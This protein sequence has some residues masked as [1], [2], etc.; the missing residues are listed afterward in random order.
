MLS[1]SGDKIETG[2][3]LMRRDEDSKRPFLTM[4]VFHFIFVICVT[5]SAFLF[6][7]KY[8]L[9]GAYRIVLGLN[10]SYEY[11]GVWFLILRRFGMIIIVILY[12]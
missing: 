5:V 2:L 6:T 12:T 10:N 11:R 9:I 7:C 3:F 8:I 1:L 4:A